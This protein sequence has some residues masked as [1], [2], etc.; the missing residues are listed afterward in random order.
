MEVIWTGMYKGRRIGGNFA[1]Y[2]LGQNIA[3]AKGVGKKG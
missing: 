1:V 3:N 2:S